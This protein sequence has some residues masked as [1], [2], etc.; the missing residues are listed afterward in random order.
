MLS[1]RA[2]SR[3]LLSN[4]SISRER[5]TLLKDR[6]KGC[7]ADNSHSHFFNSNLKSSNNSS[8]WIMMRVLI[9]RKREIYSLHHLEEAR[10]REMPNN[11]SQLINHLHQLLNYQSLCLVRAR[12]QRFHWIWSQVWSSK[13]SSEWPSQMKPNQVFMVW[14]ISTMMKL[15]NHL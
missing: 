12:K 14:S 8:S 11:N 3:S 1:P 2:I 6:H 13:R 7:P 10:I 4:P 9:S 5:S 15:W